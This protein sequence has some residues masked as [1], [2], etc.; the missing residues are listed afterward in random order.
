AE[1]AV[2]VALGATGGIVLAQL[3]LSVLKTTRAV[4]LPRLAHASLNPEVLGFVI[5]ISGAVTFFLALLP[6]WR[7]LRPGLLRDLQGAGRSSSG[8]S[9]R[10]AGRL[11][12]VAQLTFTL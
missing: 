7:T 8:R 4:H 6:A 11:L 1:S 9:L 5:L 12:V 3:V 2:L 10:L